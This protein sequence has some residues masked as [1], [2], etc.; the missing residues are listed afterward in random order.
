MYLTKL[1]KKCTYRTK[2]SATEQRRI[3]A[4]EFLVDTRDK[5]GVEKYTKISK[6]LKQF[7]EKAINIF[8]LRQSVSEVLGGD[9][10]LIKR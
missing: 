6:L 5:I 7:H 10:D 8:I 1:F 9:A 2:V 4:R 3:L